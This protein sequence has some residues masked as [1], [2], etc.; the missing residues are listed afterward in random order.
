MDKGT[1]FQVLLKLIDKVTISESSKLLQKAKNA[2]KEAEKTNGK[3]R[4]QHEKAANKYR[5]AA[6]NVSSN[7]AIIILNQLKER[8]NYKEL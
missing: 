3:E 5:T 1:A 8:F 4:E 2:E 6:G 7:I